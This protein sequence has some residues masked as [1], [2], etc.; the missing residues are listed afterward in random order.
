MKHLKEYDESIKDLATDLEDIG[1][2]IKKGWYILT[3][4][5]GYIIVAESDSKAEMMLRKKYA[6]TSY[7]FPEKG[8]DGKYPSGKLTFVESFFTLMVQEGFVSQM[9]I[10][11]DLK[12]KNPLEKDCI[13]KFNTFNSFLSCELLEKYFSDIKQAMTTEV[14][15][16]EFDDNLI[17]DIY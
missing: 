11:K 10:L 4:K 8:S 6:G 12:L 5:R 13:I 3:E 17:D 14:R 9:T 15:R 1:L 7:T 2:P 16:D